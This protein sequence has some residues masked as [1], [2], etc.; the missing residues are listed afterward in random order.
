[1]AAAI[2]RRLGDRIDGFRSSASARRA[3]SNV[4]SRRRS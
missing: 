2:L 3:S 4:Q 1:V